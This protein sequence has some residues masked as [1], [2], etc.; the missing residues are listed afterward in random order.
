MIPVRYVFRNDWV[1]VNRQIGKCSR[2]HAA[3]FFF[4]PVKLVPCGARNQW[5]RPDS[6]EK[7]PER[8]GPRPAGVDR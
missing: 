2:K 3:G 4:R 8:S 7:S 1:A 6:V 5:V